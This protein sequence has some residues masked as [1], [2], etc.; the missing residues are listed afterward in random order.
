[1]FEPTLV[2]KNTQVERITMMLQVQRVS[3]TIAR[4]TLVPF[5]NVS[6]HFAATTTT[7]SD[8]PT[9]KARIEELRKIARDSFI[10]FRDMGIRK[11]GKVPEEP[12]DAAWKLLPLLDQPVPK[13]IR[14]RQTEIEDYITDVWIKKYPNGSRVRLIHRNIAHNALNRRRRRQERLSYDQLLP[15]IGSLERQKRISVRVG[16]S[17]RLLVDKP[18]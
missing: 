3:V 18:L 1:M 15:I 12:N 9:R 6:R 17:G 13:E 8:D 14:D 7:I 4:R 16:K 11:N 10:D 5:R 2:L